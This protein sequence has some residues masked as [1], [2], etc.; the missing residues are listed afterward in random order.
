M[1]R[2]FSIYF[3]STES[4]L[5]FLV[6]SSLGLIALVDFLAIKIMGIKIIANSEQITIILSIFAL[7][8][9][10]YL[11]RTKLVQS[12]TK[13]GFV[14]LARVFNITGIAME[15]L[16]QFVTFVSLFIILS[17]IAASSNRPLYD[18]YFFTFDKSLGFDWLSYISI[19]NKYPIFNT[20]LENAYHSTFQIPA[21]FIA[22]AIFQK[23]ARLYNV[24]LCLIISVIIC[25]TIS[26]I[27]PAFGKANYMGINPINF[28]NVEM[29]AGY[30]QI[31]DIKKMRYDNKVIDLSS[32]KGVITFPSFHTCM[33]MI[34][35]WGFWGIS[36]LRFPFLLINMVMLAAIPVTGGHYLADMV[37]GAIIAVTVIYMVTRLTNWH[38]AKMEIIK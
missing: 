35:A 26:G 19:V 5:R 38:L 17:Y 11:L 2:F 1:A 29:A 7:T 33:A 18:E 37:A 27:F 12:A 34:L 36:Y 20:I 10:S 8:I 25:I 3:K 23:S 31:D 30:A 28:P 6:W 14:K 9:L 32:L 22:L 21:I 24:M 15:G 4:L 13:D 16:V